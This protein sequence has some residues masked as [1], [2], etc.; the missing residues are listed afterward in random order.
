MGRGRGGSTGFP[1][2][3]APA[4]LID[5]ATEPRSIRLF[6]P[7]ALAS[8]A[9]AYL[10]IVPFWSMRSFVKPAVDKPSATVSLRNIPISNGA[11]IPNNEDAE[12]ALI[13]LVFVIRSV[14]ELSLLPKSKFNR[15]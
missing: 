3:P 7:S 5:S 15:V 1:A 14:I 9:G 8:P 2:L 12:L 11:S 4:V 13:P 10:A 6:N